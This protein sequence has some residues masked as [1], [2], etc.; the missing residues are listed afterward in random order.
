ML[1]RRTGL[2]FAAPWATIAGTP[3][4]NLSLLESIYDDLRLYVNF[5]QPSFKLI[6]K[7]RVGNRTIKQ[8]D[9][10]KT[11]Y[12]RLLERQDIS[13]PAKAR[14]MAVYVQLKPAELRRQIDLK[15]AK[16]WKILYSSDKGRTLQ[17]T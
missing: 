13:L 8:Y 4:Q 7:Q 9:L 5:F 17:V 15:I 3:S 10:P 16:L 1:N 11:P 6:A 14:L 2:S 12:Q